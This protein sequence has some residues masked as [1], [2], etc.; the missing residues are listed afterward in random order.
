MGS[1]ETGRVEIPRPAGSFGRPLS[2]KVA[3]ETPNEMD[4]LLELQEA[5]LPS[6]VQVA[7]G[8]LLRCYTGRDEVTF[9]FEETPLRYA[10]MGKA[11]TSN[12]TT[13]SFAVHQKMTITDMLKQVQRD[14]KTSQDTSASPLSNGAVFS[15]GVS[16]RSM[17]TVPVLDD[18]PGGS[19][20]LHKALPEKVTR[21]YLCPF[22]FSMDAILTQG[23]VQS[24]SSCQE[25]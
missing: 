13:T 6:V 5:I 21:I 4:Q 8:L 19:Q 22:S 15:T 18:A 14:Y 24:S 12:A 3:L 1:E 25:V 10:A 2:L 20:T 16:I 23:T 11:N 9:G 17:S 7:W